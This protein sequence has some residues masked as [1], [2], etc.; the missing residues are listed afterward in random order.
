MAKII[1][2]KSCG[3]CPYGPDQ[4]GI[5]KEKAIFDDVP[6]G[7]PLEDA[8][9]ESIEC[10]GC[11]ENCIMLVRT[12]KFIACENRDDVGRVILEDEG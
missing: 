6:S 11:E 4:S 7:C 2:V 12:R 8:P 10:P 3:N 1:R 9:D 5:C